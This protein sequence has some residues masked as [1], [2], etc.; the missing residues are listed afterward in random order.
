MVLYFG[1]NTLD[2]VG[3]MWESTFT[4]RGRTL[5]VTLSYFKTEACNER[6]GGLHGPGVW[7]GFRRGLERVWRGSG[8]GREGRRDVLDEAESGWSREDPTWSPRIEL[9]MELWVDLGRVCAI[10]LM[11]T[12]RVL[13]ALTG[14]DSSFTL[15]TKYLLRYLL[16][17]P[18]L[19]T[20]T[21]Y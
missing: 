1:F 21:D 3:V 10:Q 20:Y 15:R 14:G 18:Y 17:R 5:L 19:Y 6:G 8:G 13:S 2:H 9:F 7:R 12:V 4:Q 16:C 11:G